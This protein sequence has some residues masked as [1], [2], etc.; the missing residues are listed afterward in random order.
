LTRDVIISEVGPRDGLQ[1]VKRVMPVEA[2]KRWVRALAAAG[3]AEIEVGSFVNPAR[4]PQLANTEQVV[5]DAITLPGLSVL[6]LV[7]N[8]K[9][10][11]LAFKAGA[12]RVTMPVS[13]SR[14]HS[15]ANINRTPEEAV[16]AVADVVRLRDSLPDAAQRGVEVGLSTAFGCTMEGLVSED[17]VIRLAVA[18]A[19][20]GADSVGLSDTTGMGNPAQVKRLFIR[21]R[22]EL[23]AKA[24]GAHLHNTR[25]QGLA[26]VWAAL[27]AGVTTFDSSQAGI[28]GCPYAPGATGNIVT[29]DLVFLLEAAGLRTGI[30]LD[31]LLAA[32]EILKEALPGEPL[33]GHVVEAGLPK[34]FLYAGTR[35]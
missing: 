1:S 27:E 17:A 18:A 11:E 4:V 31:K 7:P 20:A 32:R 12:H 15:L 25:G 8:L 35:S 28:G 13:V 23:G 30:D 29:E 33:Y 14:T 24:G 16:K 2:R 19:E 10:A 3:F 6:A 22:Q 34:G 21:L 26:N 9:G 5:A